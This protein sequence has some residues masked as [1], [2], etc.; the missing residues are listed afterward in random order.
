MVVRKSS[1]S[2]SMQI[3]QHEYNMIGFF[4]NCSFSALDLVAICGSH[5]VHLMRA[6]EV[7]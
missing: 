3:L 2:T 1:S 4:F 6:Y 5:T 7:I